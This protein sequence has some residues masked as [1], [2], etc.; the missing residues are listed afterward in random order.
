[1]LINK[2][3]CNDL[4]EILDLQYLA[5][6]SEAKL[7]DN[8]NIP[9]LTQTL[10]DIKTEFERGIFLKAIDEEGHIV[11]SVRA[12]SDSGTLYIGK[13]I[14]RPDLHGQGIGTKLLKEM[15]RICP[16]KRYELYTGKF[17]GFDK[18]VLEYIVRLPIVE[19]EEF[20]STY[21]VTI[22]RN[23]NMDAS[24]PDQCELVID[25]LCCRSCLDPLGRL[26]TASNITPRE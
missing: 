6:Q 19:R 3:D 12:H 26:S 16:H 2:A 4:L 7:Y 22:D 23:G 9:P 18:K 25:L 15:E 13:L 20:L 8:P 10:E 5:Y 24:D 11:G 1:M 21:G 17:I 14:V